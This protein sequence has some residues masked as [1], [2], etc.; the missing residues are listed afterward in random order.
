M[1]VERQICRYISGMRKYIYFFFQE[2]NYR[3]FYHRFIERHR[4]WCSEFD[5]VQTFPDGRTE[6]LKKGIF[7]DY[8]IRTSCAWT[9]A[10][11]EYWAERD[12]SERE[13]DFIEIA[14]NLYTTKV[15]FQ[16]KK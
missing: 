15:S 6:P 11:L 2:E 10:V 9:F 12:F 5:I 14:N 4:K 13:E 7:Y 3:L 16:G 8:Y 1:E